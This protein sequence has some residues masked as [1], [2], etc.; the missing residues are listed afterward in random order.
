M[1]D[2]KIV[3]KDLSKVVHVFFLKSIFISFAFSIG[4]VQKMNAKS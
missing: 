2:L 3:G 4:T 1:S